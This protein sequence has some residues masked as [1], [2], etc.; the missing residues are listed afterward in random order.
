[1]LF[2]IPPL[3][4]RKG[5]WNHLY[6]GWALK[7]WC[8]WTVVLE[9]TLESPFCKEIKPVNPKGNQ[10]WILIGKTDAEVEAPI[11][12]SPDAKSQLIGKDPD[13]G[14]DWGQEEK[15]AK[16]HEMA[17]CHHQLNGHESEQ[18]LGGSEAQRN[19]GF[20]I[21]WGCRVGHWLSDWTT[22]TWA[23]LVWKQRIHK[24]FLM[25]HLRTH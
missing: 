5:K 18:T 21:P 2:I 1:M 12:W 4:S 23:E 11:L 13:A 19:L 3:F 20:C 7:N 16:E 6:M 8:F 9:K 10:S 22:T 25:T 14:K 17:E 24:Q 15:G